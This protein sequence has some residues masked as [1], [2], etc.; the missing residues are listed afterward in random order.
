LSGYY[1]TPDSEENVNGVILFVHGD[2]EMHYDAFGYYEPV[3]KHILDS[4]YAIFSWDKPGVGNS[5]GDWLSQS[6]LDRQN[7]VRAAVSFLKNRYYFEEGE[8]GLMG[9][10]QADGLCRPLLR[11]MTILDLS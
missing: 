9:F 3:W 11:I 10:S 5:S 6:M 8:V 4:G 2:G 1:H 7:E